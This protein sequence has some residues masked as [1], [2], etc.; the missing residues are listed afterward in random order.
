MSKRVLRYFGGLI[1]RQENWLNRMAAKGYRLVET[2]RLFYKFEQCSPNSY[3]YRVEFVGHKLHSEA[4]KY[5]EFLHELGYR[6]FWKNI[7]LNFALFK[8]KWRPWA[9][10][11]GQLATSSGG[12]NRELLI[13][14]KRQDGKPFSLHTDPSEIIALYKT[15][16]K[17]WLWSAV[18][19]LMLLVMILT[20]YIK[21]SWLAITGATV[22]VLWGLVPFAYYS[23][24][25]SRYKRQE[26]LYE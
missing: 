10:G 19:G 1:K 20:G 12:L 17:A 25:L 15:M 23:L 7:N 26:R 2:G 6:T 3:E 18:P 5:R 4:Q 8:M 14:E 16:R 21:F 9:Q 22:L 11:T 24:E 13:V